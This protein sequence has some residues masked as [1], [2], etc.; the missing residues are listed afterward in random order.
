MN[1]INKILF[2]FVSL[3]L[4]FTFIVET[5]SAKQTVIDDAQIKKTKNFMLK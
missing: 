2:S 5:V 4:C 1:K 3:I